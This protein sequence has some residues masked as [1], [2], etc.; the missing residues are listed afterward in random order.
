M[1][2]KDKKINYSCWAC[3]FIALAVFLFIVYIA[4]ELIKIGAE[5]LI[6]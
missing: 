5:N 6:P 4:G 2:D 1:T 3:Y